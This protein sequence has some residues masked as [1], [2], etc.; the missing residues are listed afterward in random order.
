MVDSLRRD[1]LSPDN[2]RVTFTP[3]FDQFAREEFAFQRAFTRYGGTGLSMP[4]IWAG[5]MILHKEY[6]QPFQPMNAL[7]KLI[8]VNG[9]RR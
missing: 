3:A 4:A 2:P 5:S 9:Y 8:T 1:Y 7:E 6:V